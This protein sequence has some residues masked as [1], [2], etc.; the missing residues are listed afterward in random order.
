MLL[1]EELA[2]R[3]VAVFVVTHRS[4]L[5]FQIGNVIIARKEKGKTVLV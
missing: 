4:D 3:G 2:D 1:L 5:Q